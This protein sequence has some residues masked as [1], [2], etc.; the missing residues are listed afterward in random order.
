VPTSADRGCHI[1]SVTD[2]YGHILG[3]LDRANKYI[4]NKSKYLYCDKMSQI[5]NCRTRRERPCKYHV[6]V[7]YSSD[8]GNATTEEQLFSMQSSATAISYQHTR[9]ARRDVF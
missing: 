9:T 6:T 4:C 7:A 3:F 2:P 8:K 1:I 5:Q